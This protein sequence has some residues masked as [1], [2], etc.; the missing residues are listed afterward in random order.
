MVVTDVVVKVTAKH[1][2]AAVATVMGDN[3][4]LGVAWVT[5]VLAITLVI[6]AVVI[7]LFT[8]IVLQMVRQKKHSITQS[9]SQSVTQSRWNPVGAAEIFSGLYL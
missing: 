3:A 6:A 2:A 9:V 1:W 7:A 8:S 5:I 4:L